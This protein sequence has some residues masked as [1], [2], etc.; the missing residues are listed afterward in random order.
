VSIAFGIAMLLML[1][2][3]SV[4]QQPHI[5]VPVLG[6]HDNDNRSGNLPA[7]ALSLHPS[8]DHPPHPAAMTVAVGPVDAAAVQNVTVP[9]FD[10]QIGST[11]VQ[12]FG[13]LTYNVTALAQ[14]DPDGYGPAYL[15][16]GL[17]SSGYWYQVGISYHW[18]TTAGSYPSFGF[19]YQVFGPTDKPVYPATGGSGLE[20]FSASVNSGDDILLSLNFTGASV[21]MLAR[22]WDTGAMAST[23]YSSFGSSTF[24]GNRTDPSNDNGFFTGLMTEWFH[25]APYTGSE[26]GV[27]YTN[28]KVNLTSAWMWLEEFESGTT[29]SV[30]FNNRTQ[31]PVTFSN[32]RQ[33]YPFSS[34]GASMYISDHQFIT[35]LLSGSSSRVT[36]LP[37]ASGDSP[38][39]F[40]ANYTFSGR[41]RTSVIGAGAT[42]LEADPGTP[43]TVS[44]ESGVSPF[45][46]WVFNGASGTEVTFQA[47]ENSTYAFYHLVEETV[48]YQIALGG[49]QLPGS[50]APELH[51]EVPPSSASSDP[52]PVTV[53]QALNTVPSVIF[54]V[55][56]SDAGITN[57]TIVGPAGERWVASAQNWTIS[58]EGLIPGPIDLYQQYEVSLGYSVV[59]GGGGGRG[60]DVP[61]QPPDFVAASAG[62]LASVQLSS[63]GRTL[64]WFDAGSSYFFTSLLNGSNPDERWVGSAQNAS[65]S[66]SRISATG[67][68]LSEVYAPQYYV[69]LAVNDASGGTISNDSGWFDGGSP[70]MTNASAYQGWRFEGWNGS[71][72][73]AYT[74]NNTSID[75]PVAG[76]VTEEARFFV[77]LTI[78]AD[79][80][81][82]IAFSSPSETGVV[83]AGMT[84]TFYVPPSQV[85]LSASPSL[86]VYSFS[87]WQRPGAGNVPDRSL[88]LAVD[89]PSA[90]KATSSYN[91]IALL[92]ALM[93]VVAL[94]LF[95]IAGA[96][97]FRGRQRRGTR[98]SVTVAPS[99]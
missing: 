21:E 37:S 5:V 43:I 90:V 68:E 41:P 27:T 13:T 20:N 32:D 67:E 91:Y 48:W 45:D 52:A 88:V 62:S 61:S 55:L 30:V 76:P 97:W 6:H 71:G 19:S 44:I 17:T 26:G 50:I 33:I 60:S 96:F 39:S 94:A 35:G 65:S 29:N 53:T 24:L 34:D 18:P 54:A 12:N 83:P 2:G 58:G 7:T 8:R 16:N 40:S 59:G 49:D 80:G 38:L 70:L 23:N 3:S 11:F 75:L 42:F 82:N 92:E 63:T 47:G 95:G 25:V 78:T 84:R 72:P 77:Q 15:L 14:T 66:L 46:R 89:S 93:V 31:G 10:E 51:Y 9:N 64:A 85:K 73:G 56:G 99:T 22:D 81:T 57:A 4:G 79:P 1:V 98:T 86:F 87:S 74:G 69:H 36:L 28:D